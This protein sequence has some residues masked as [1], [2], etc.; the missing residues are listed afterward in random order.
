VE[1]GR[2]E[3]SRDPVF[4]PSTNKTQRKHVSARVCHMLHACRMR[5]YVEYLVQKKTEFNALLAFG[6]PFL[7]H[8][9]QYQPMRYPSDNSI[10]DLYACPLSSHI[11]LCQNRMQ[12]LSCNNGTFRIL[13]FLHKWLTH[14]SRY[15]QNIGLEI[16]R[17]TGAHLVFPLSCSMMSQ[18][19]LG[20]THYFSRRRLIDLLC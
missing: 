10:G 3:C 13:T 1:V 5:L 16:R 19:E 14:Y 4:F 7:V 9:L 18:D 17:A 20:A 12:G 15:L 8:T 6:G 11:R 2:L